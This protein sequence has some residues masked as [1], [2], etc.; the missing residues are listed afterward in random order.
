MRL[1]GR[2]LASFLSLGS[3]AA[4]AQ[5]TPPSPLSPEVVAAAIVAAKAPTPPAPYVL[6][7]PSKPVTRNQPLDPEV[8]KTLDPNKIL[9]F[10]AVYTP[11]V[12][13]AIL[14]RKAADAGKPFGTAD[15]PAEIQDS[16]TYVA[17]LP[18]E[19]TDVT[20]PDRLVDT[21][22]VIV[23][24]PGSTDRA[25]IVQ[26]VWV[27]PDTTQLRNILGPTVPERAMLA[28]FAPG[29]IEAGKEI[30]IVYAGTVYAQR[31]EVTPADIAA[32]R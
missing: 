3:A 31:V 6:K 19:R 14:A 7:G 1:R 24:P 27:K 20:G 16:L 28:A 17:A 11:F 12:R 15:I 9:T 22:F 30:V 13:A 21:I 4:F 2:L 25:Q 32:W 8:A 23:T 29:A 10:G 18:W 5:V 26:P